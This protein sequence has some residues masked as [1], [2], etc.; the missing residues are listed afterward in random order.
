MS[1]VN[2]TDYK[3]WEDRSITKKKLIELLDQV[4]DHAMVFIESSSGEYEPQN[5]GSIDIDGGR[6]ILYYRRKDW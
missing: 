1:T 2:I 5:I 4:D 3:S 6:I